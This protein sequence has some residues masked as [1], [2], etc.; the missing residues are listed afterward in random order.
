[1]NGFHDLVTRHNRFYA[2]IQA[3]P[4]NPSPFRPNGSWAMTSY[5]DG[6]DGGPIPWEIDET[7]LAT[8]ELWNHYAYLSGAD[9]RKYLDAV[10]PAIKN[11]ADYMTTCRD[12][13]NGMQCQQNEDD[14]VVQT[15]TMHGAITVYIGLEAAVAA[16]GAKGDT[17]AAV[18][19]WRGRAGELRSA[20]EGLYDAQ[21]HA[22]RM[23]YPQPNFCGG[24]VCLTDFSVGGWMLWPGEFKPYSD[25]TMAGEA[26]QVRKTMDAS[27]AGPRGAYE[28]KG[29]LG[30]AH[31]WSAPTPDQYR[32][33]TATLSYMAASVTSPTGLFGE[34]W[35]R[36]DGKPHPIEDQPHVW[37]HCL[38][39][40]SAIQILGAEAYTPQS[41]DYVADHLQP[42]VATS[43]LPPT[44]AGPG[45]A[46]PL[47]LCL[48][49][50]A[51]YG[52]STTFIASRSWK[53]R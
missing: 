5:A 1:M 21:V 52:V 31:A 35:R 22:Y 6:I 45:L 13:S 12:P 23:N 16:A 24:N 36:Y 17:S 32:E 50:L 11:A 15:Q 28:G 38:F 26:A 7:G 51:I 46:V 33:L 37:E 9:A 20:M 19:G 3:S 41:S 8:W 27:L 44:A 30:L 48:V 10:Y 42:A 14:N 29:L 49:A 18:D 39:Y 40:L 47:V 34:S 25:P 53:R 2:R 43:Q 4:S